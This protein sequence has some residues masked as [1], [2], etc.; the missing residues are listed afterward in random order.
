LTIMR[1]LFLDSRLFQQFSRGDTSDSL[2]FCRL[3][4]CFVHDCVEI[5]MQYDTEDF[6]NF[7]VTRTRDDLQSQSKH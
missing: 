7:W 6:D 4:S 1:N 3:V 2:I 5:V